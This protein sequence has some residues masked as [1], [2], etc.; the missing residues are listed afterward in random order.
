MCGNGWRRN[1]HYKSPKKHIVEIE[2]SRRRKA[3]SLFCRLRSLL[4]SFF[5]PPAFNASLFFFDWLPFYP[6]RSPIVF[7]SV[8]SPFF[9]AVPNG[10]T[11]SLI[12]SS[13]L[14]LSLYS[15]FF[16]SRVYT[17]QNSLS[18][19]YCRTNSLLLLALQVLESLKLSNSYRPS[20]NQFLIQD[21]SWNFSPFPNLSS[22][23]EDQKANTK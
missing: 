1:L 9:S 14:S 22:S 6:I 23:G 4:S 18:K 10:L 5:I 7:A 3:A 13:L 16:L 15:L 12:C 2:C 20:F 11:S 21:P 17:H 19:E 8:F